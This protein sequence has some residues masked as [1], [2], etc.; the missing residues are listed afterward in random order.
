MLWLCNNF[1]AT[2]FNI[3]IFISKFLLSIKCKCF[4][5]SK[6][7]HV[8]TAAMFS[9]SKDADVKFEGKLEA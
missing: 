8:Q 6:Q 7:Y 2:L 4:R 3:E 1:Y 5:I 9:V